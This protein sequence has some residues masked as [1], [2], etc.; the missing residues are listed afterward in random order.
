MMKT[1]VLNGVLACGLAMLVL[2][3]SACVAENGEESPQADEAPAPVESG[4][5][6]VPE[7]P[8]QDRPIRSPEQQ[9]T[10][11]D[12]WLTTA[13][14]PPT[15]GIDDVEAAFG[16]PQARTTTPLPNDY[17][18]GQIDTVVVMEYDRGVSVS[19]YKVTGGREFLFQA[20]VTGPGLLRNDLFDV[21]SSWADV[22][23]AFGV[24]QGRTD[25]DPYYQCGRCDVEEPVFFSIVD[26]LI[27][28]ILITYYLD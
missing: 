10:L 13:F 20:E 4:L 5:A 1:L 19:I 27:A 6:T 14:F 26:D 7:P 21:G 23:A 24:P 18:A 17:V 22:V 28:G 12:D 8:D 25:G 2:A 3:S 9:A 11:R 15:T 16:P